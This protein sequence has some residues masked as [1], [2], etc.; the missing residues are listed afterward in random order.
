MNAMSDYTRTGDASYLVGKTK[1]AVFC[2]FEDPDY[3][4]FFRDSV[5]TVEAFE[6]GRISS[7]DAAKRFLAWRT[8]MSLPFQS[9]RMRWFVLTG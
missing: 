9:G 7:A 3:A 4:A 6:A 8:N 5:E 2:D 1:N